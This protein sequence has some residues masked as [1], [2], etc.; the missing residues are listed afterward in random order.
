MAVSLSRALLYSDDKSIKTL[1]VFSGSDIVAAY[2]VCLVFLTGCVQLWTSY[3]VINQ[4]SVVIRCP[5]RLS[6]YKITSDTIANILERLPPRIPTSNSDPLLLIDY[7]LGS[8]F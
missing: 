3:Q 7:S 2:D 1:A 8:R 6:N 4:M 5:F